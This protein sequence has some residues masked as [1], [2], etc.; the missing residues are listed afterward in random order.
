VLGRLS[1]PPQLHRGATL[2][3]TGVTDLVSGSAQTYC[4]NASDTTNDVV[5]ILCPGT[6]GTTLAMRQGNV[7]ISVWNMGV[8]DQWNVMERTTL[9]S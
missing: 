9:R 1:N 6:G 5:P 2:F 3:V 4:L 8:G 7:T